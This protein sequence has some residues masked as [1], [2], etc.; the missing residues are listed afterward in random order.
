MTVGGCARLRSVVSLSVIVTKSD[1]PSK[2]LDYMVIDWSHL[3]SQNC[4]WSWNITVVSCGEVQE[5]LGIFIF[6]DK[7]E[8]CVGSVPVSVYFTVEDVVKLVTAM[9]AKSS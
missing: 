9:V 2:V 5:S 3:W 8:P 7:W 6:S 4:Y 1:I